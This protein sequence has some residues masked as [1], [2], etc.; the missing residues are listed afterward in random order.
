M[1][2][3]NEEEW[4]LC[5]APL[6][7]YEVSNK[8][9]M[10]H[11]RTKRIRKLNENDTY[12]H[13]TYCDKQGVT[14]CGRVH[15]LVAQCFL[16][17]YFEGCVVNHKDGNKHNNCVEN[18]ECCSYKENTRHWV[19]NLSEVSQAIAVFQDKC[20]YPFMLFPT[21]ADYARWL[22]VMPTASTRVFR[23]INFDKGGV[24]L[25]ALEISREKY[26]QLIEMM[27]HGW[28][29]KSA[30]VEVQTTIDLE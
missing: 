6:D 26:L 29:L 1:N 4:R 21:K 16:D 17:D 30:W 27:N 3:K 9:R 25:K 28:L 10:R 5:P 22:G 23:R 20:W 24:K 15:K 18:L 8:G 2:N 11:A 12:L 19:T 13:I 14:H 7:I